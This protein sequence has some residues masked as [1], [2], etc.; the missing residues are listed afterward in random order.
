MAHQPLLDQGLLIEASRLHSDTPLLVGLLWTSDQ[1]DAVASTWLHT[2]HKI[3]TPCSRRD[4]NRH[5]QKASVL[6]PTP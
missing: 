6:W 2:T 3:Q 4:S 5:S 1:P